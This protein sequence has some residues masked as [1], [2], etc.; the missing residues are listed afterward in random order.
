MKRY[1][2]LTYAL[3]ITTIL[4]TVI[5]IVMVYSASYIWASFKYNN[6]YHYFLRQLIFG[7]MGIIGMFVVSNVPYHLYKKHATLIFSVVLGLLIIVLIPGIGIVRGGARS[8]IGIGSFSIQPSEFMKIACIILLSKYLS[9][10]YSDM[11]K[12]LNI[13][14]LLG[15][16]VVI[17]GLIMLQPDFGTG[18]IIVAT[19]LV[20]LFVAGVNLTYFIY[21]LI[22]GGV[23]IT[24]LIISAP[25]RLRRIFA[26]LDPWSDPLGA[27]FQIIQSLYA[28]SPGGLF[29]V[30]LG[31]SI[32]KHFYLP[33]PQTDFIFA[34]LV[35]ELGFI[36]GAFVLFLY[37][38]FFLSALMISLNAQ[39]NFGRFLSLGITIS[40]F[41]QFFINIGVV[42]GLLPV[43]GITLPFLSY[44]GS[45]LTVTLLGVGIILNISKHQQR[46]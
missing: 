22:A 21:L 44:G 25:Y 35:E 37:T 13:L 15:V 30:G 4:L 27:G 18:M 19:T 46:Y 34:I 20:M 6:P 17:F 41:I 43:T 1:I 7:S 42:I 14:L 2:N 33:E 32:Q 39:D 5:G 31:N 23:G 9:D 11:E 12:P 29:G 45:S 10:Y 3:I 26:Y 40:I 24:A 28:I 16:V 8:W 38:I 36:G